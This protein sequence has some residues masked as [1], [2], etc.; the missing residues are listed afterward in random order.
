MLHAFRRLLRDCYVLDG[1]D[2]GFVF[3][4]SA[5]GNL[6]FTSTYSTNFPVSFT[7]PT[8]GRQNRV[9]QSGR[10]SGQP[11]ATTV[12]GVTTGTFTYCNQD[13]RDEVMII[14][15]GTVTEIDMS[16]EGSHWVNTGLTAGVFFLCPGAYVR[17]FNSVIPIIT[18][19]YK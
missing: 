18:T 12:G 14:S 15:G 3:G 19:I 7:D 6:L 1:G 9:F 2:G 16:E 13:G 8:K 17:I 5:I 4:D 11:I 10:P